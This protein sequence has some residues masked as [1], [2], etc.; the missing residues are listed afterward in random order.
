MQAMRYKLT[1][2][3]KPLS[4]IG[5]GFRGGFSSWIE[6]FAWL[7]RGSLARRFLKLFFSYKVVVFVVFFE[8]R[9]PKVYIE[10]R[11]AK[12]QLVLLTVRLIFARELNFRKLWATKK[13]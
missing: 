9:K 12:T 5:L 11:V 4:S 2:H 6:W 1:L 3:C 7:A 10:R 8:R 13:T